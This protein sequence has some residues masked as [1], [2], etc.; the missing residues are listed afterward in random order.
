MRP[1]TRVAELSSFSLAALDLDQ[2]KAAMSN[3][4]H[5]W[6]TRWTRAC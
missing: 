4:V 3:N 2:P 6:K 5:N 1:L